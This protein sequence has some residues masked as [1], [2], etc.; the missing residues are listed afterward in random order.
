VPNVKYGVAAACWLLVIA[1]LGW[2]GRPAGDPHA[3]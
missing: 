3:G 2:Q 1:Y